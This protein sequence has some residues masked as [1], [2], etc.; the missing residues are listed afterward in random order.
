LAIAVFRT[1]IDGRILA[2][3]V[4]AVYFLTVGLPRQFWGINIWPRLGVPAA[5]SLF[6]DTRVVTAGLECRR[7]GLDPLTFNP[8]D[9]DGRTLNYPRVWLL[10]RWLGL[11]QSHTDLLAG[12]FIALF[13]VAIYF[14]LGRI[15]L[16]E[17]TLV[18]L[19]LCSSSVMF[20]IERGNTDIVVFA[21]LALAVVMW[22]C[23][24]RR[25]EMA[26]PVVVLLAAILK[27]FPVFG[28]PAYLLLRRRQA[29]I[30][31][32][33]CLAT[34]AVYAV[35]FAADLEAL[36]RGTPQ[37]QYNSYGARILPA[38]VYH[39]LV[40]GRWQ[41]GTL[42]KQALAVV[43]LLIAAPLAWLLGRRRRPQPDP[44]SAGWRRLA[45]YLGSLLFLG[46]FGVSN[47]WDY[48]LVFLLLTLPQLFAW[49][50]D[51]SPDP[52]GG[53]A[54]FATITVLVLLWIGALSQWLA[55]ADEV[56][57]WATAALLLGLLS[58]AIPSLRELWT[59]GE[60]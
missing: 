10:L 14:L 3:G 12:V 50:T 7:V 37:G 40:P 31:A 57:T 20:G 27:I 9:P 48:R 6:F 2:A 18:S 15:S 47:N 33:G 46:T 54:A 28:L 51:P 49:I 17:G 24:S 21:L 19:A 45:F 41:G 60:D 11:N 25:N 34:L 30:A 16:G 58:A 43:P 56:V 29:A 59:S 44:E 26:S 13:L 32:L 42:T 39:H 8:C 53:M 22:R 36:A 4:L 1:D 38:I 23:G 52:R 55:A 5:P 35:F